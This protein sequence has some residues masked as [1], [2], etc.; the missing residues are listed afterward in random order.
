V[1]G[2]NDS[3]YAELLHDQSNVQLTMVNLPAVNTPQFDWV[4][5]RLPNRA[6]P[7]PPIFQPEVVAEA[8]VHAAE[9]HRREWNVAW[10][11]TKA[12]VGNNLAPAYADEYLARHGYE[13]QQT[14]EPEPPGRPHN[15]WEPL[16]G[17][18]GAH[19]RFD[20]QAKRRSLL[21]EANA[22]RGSIG[23]GLAALGLVVLGAGLLRKR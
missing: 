5:S 13:S 23:I 8:I 4:L 18:H 21:Y 14:D 17:D 6:Q 1:Q 10:P 20:A 12:I 9:E 15:L 3:L 16:P 19:G 7:V 11:T 2:F 22:R